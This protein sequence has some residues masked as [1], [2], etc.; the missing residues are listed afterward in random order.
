MSIKVVV[1][2][3]DGTLIESNQV[4]YDAYFQVFPQDN[5]WEKVIRRV[6]KRS[7]E[8]SRYA[9]IDEIL[10][11]K[12]W[13]PASSEM[14]VAEVDR[15][16]EDYGKRVFSEVKKCPARLSVEV[17][18]ERLCK[19]LRLYLSS[20]TP[21]HQLYE[22]VDHRGWTGY[23]QNIFGFPREKSAT[24]K[25][26]LEQENILPENLLVVGDGESDRISARDTGCHFFKV[27]PET[28]ILDVMD[29]ISSNNLRAEC[30]S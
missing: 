15:L 23:F 3:F 2:D 30:E 13:A 29:I 8:K 12:G 10:R 20:T 7:Y 11:E 24:L 19:I 4:K 17:V 16:S 18:L 1:F 14:L 5:E 9:V 21:E 28:D 6:L 27:L 22:L 26:I 25:M